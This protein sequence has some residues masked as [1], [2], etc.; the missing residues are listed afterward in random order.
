VVAAGQA[1]RR[2]TEEG[3]GPLFYLTGKLRQG[4]VER[5]FA[6]SGIDVGVM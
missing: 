1:A 2:L 6:R 4:L 3:M 5:L